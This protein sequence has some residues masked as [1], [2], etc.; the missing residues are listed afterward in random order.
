M[1]GKTSRKD[2]CLMGLVASTLC[3]SVLGTTIRVAKE[4]R[5]LSLSFRH[6][7]EYNFANSRLEKAARHDA[8]RLPQP[9]RQNLALGADT[10]AAAETHTPEHG[11]PMLW[12]ARH[13]HSTPF[14]GL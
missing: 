4:W 5:R 12:S 10:G 3:S 14:A 8:A 13:W 1:L 11:A 9:D 6:S 2:H 7:I